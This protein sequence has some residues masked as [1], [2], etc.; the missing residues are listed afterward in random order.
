MLVI[1]LSEDVLCSTLVTVMGLPSTGKVSILT[2]TDD[3][4]NAANLDDGRIEV[5][6][7]ILFAGI[8]QR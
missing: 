8:V 3:T 4:L 1:G 7:L 2:N 5:I 6:I